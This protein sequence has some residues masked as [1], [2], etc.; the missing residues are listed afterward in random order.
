MGL[1]SIERMENI[2]VSS[3]FV[4]AT[5]T[6]NW[7]VAAAAAVVNLWYYSSNWKFQQEN[8]LLIRNQLKRAT[9]TI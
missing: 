6:A 7:A 8:K 1:R 9:H 4:T 3:S 5:V 2:L